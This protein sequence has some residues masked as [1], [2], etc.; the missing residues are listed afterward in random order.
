[1]RPRLT[2]TA[3]A[4]AAVGAS[5]AIGHA[6]DPA[7]RPSPDPARDQPWKRVQLTLREPR[8]DE[9]VFSTDP[10]R[11]GSL[12]GRNRRFDAAEPEGPVPGNYTDW[13]TPLRTLAP[14][15]RPLP[16][17]STLELDDVELG[18]AE[19]NRTRVPASATLPLEG[20]LP[21]A[22]ARRLFGFVSEGTTKMYLGSIPVRIRAVGPS[23]VAYAIPAGEIPRG[24]AVP[25]AEGLHVQARVDGGRVRFSLEA[26]QGAFQVQDR[27]NALGATLPGG[28][29][30]VV[31]RDGDDL[32][33][34][35]FDSGLEHALDRRTIDATISTT[36]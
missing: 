3:I 26:P 36:R 9:V 24:T 31:G 7:H 1:M 34:E 6:P 11:T 8:G 29:Y 22:A 28:F 32:V 13:P 27:C 30:E 14:L 15:V 21:R 35:R 10:N 20:T 2:A 16:N 4:V 33:L 12:V 25:S 19:T 5:L 18:A 17:G 23:G